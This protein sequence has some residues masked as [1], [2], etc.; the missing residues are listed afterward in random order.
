MV[1]Y[2][3]SFS[4]G[5]FLQICLIQGDFSTAPRQSSTDHYIGH[6]PVAVSRDGPELRVEATG[7]RERDVVHSRM[8]FPMFRQRCLRCLSLT[9]MMKLPREASLV[10][11]LF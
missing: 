5:Y 4:L 8:W 2:L 1:I 6:I 9:N 7:R 11:F 3:T 10:A